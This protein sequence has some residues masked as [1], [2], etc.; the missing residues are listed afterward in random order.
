[1][2][3]HDNNN[4][5]TSDKTKI[6]L[7]LIIGTILIAMSG[8]DGWGWLLFFYVLTHINIEIE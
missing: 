7:A 8:N 3:K 1:M 4:G 2:M 6:Q 5:E